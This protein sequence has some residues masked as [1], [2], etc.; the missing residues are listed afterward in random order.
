MYNIIKFFLG[1]LFT[2][3]SAQFLKRLFKIPRPDY[4]TLSSFKQ[5]TN[6]Y[7][8]PSG[9]AAMYSFIFFFLYL[10]YFP[11]SIF[12]IIGIP[13]FLY[14]LKDTYLGGYHDLPQIIGGIVYGFFI[15]YII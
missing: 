9:H 8:F 2:I 5:K 14:L 1:L 13:L 3:Y 10:H 12:L 7:G 15:A 6:G 11:T 4:H